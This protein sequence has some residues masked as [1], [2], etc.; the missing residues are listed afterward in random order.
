M[1]REEEKY[2]LDYV[3]DFIAKI[4]S[5]V[6]NNIIRDIEDKTWHAIKLNTVIQL[7]FTWNLNYEDVNDDKEKNDNDM[8]VWFKKW[9]Q[10][11]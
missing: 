1:M 8:H 11:F 5:W 2:K 10:C 6:N 4:W 9:V 7:K 3:S